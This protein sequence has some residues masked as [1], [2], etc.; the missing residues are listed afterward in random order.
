MQSCRLSQQELN[1]ADIII[2][3]S[4]SQAAAVHLMKKSKRL[5]R[6]TLLPKK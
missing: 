1:R 2:A 5:E 3:Q 6:D 4:S